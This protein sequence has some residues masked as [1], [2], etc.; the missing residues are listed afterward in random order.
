[1]R[2]TLPAKRKTSS[3]GRTGRLVA[4]VAVPRLVAV[5]RRFQPGRTPSIHFPPSVTV[6]LNRSNALMT[7]AFAPVTVSTAT[8]CA[9]RSPT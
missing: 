3:I 8:I 4:A 5:R 9:Q 1:M 7:T 6:G 2:P